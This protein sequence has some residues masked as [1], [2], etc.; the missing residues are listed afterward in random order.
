MQSDILT[1]IDENTHKFSRGQKK[2]ARFITEHF[3]KA[4]FL[5]AGKLAQLVGIS[6]ST[7]VRFAADIGY[8]GY[9]EMRRALQDVVR[10]RLTGVQRI[11]AS[12]DM[13]NSNDEILL[14]I[15]RS[16]AENVR[17]TL[18]S[19][20]HENFK[21]AVAAIIEAKK[22]FI[23]GLRT[24]SALSSF[25]GFYFDL[26]FDNV[27]VLNGDDDIHIARC[28]PGD[29]FIGI[30]FPRYSHQTVSLLKTAKKNGSTVIAITDAAAS[31]ISKI[32]DIKLFA[33]SDM[34]SF[35]DSLVAPLSV[36]N[37]LIV[38]VG[39][40]EKEQLPKRFQELETL[41]SERDVYEK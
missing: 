3:D 33:K 31:P 23:L 26:L 20:D 32:A 22:I 37:A 17:S 7:V 34:I 9:P 12:K 27:K 24:S 40:A 8:P 6:E 13:L 35:A 39:F 1:V 10:G 28:Q 18:D 19:I 36:I 38:A 41:W 11:E 15:L 4:A 14:A 29:V 30:S 16:D 25:M 5:T 2:I 21:K